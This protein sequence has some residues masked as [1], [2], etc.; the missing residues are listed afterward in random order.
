MDS[1][2]GGAMNFQ[3]VVVELFSCL[4]KFAINDGK[5]AVLECGE[6]VLVPGSDVNLLLFSFKGKVDTIEI[7][8]G[9][10]FPL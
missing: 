4:V 8:A 2:V 5:E 1:V 10:E 9:V 3:Y 6:H 7:Q